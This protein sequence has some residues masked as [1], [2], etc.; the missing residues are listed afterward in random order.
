ML[1]R[2]MGNQSAA[3]LL[4]VGVD[5]RLQME[6][7]RVCCCLSLPLA[8]RCQDGG[9]LFR[10]YRWRSRRAGQ[11]QGNGLATQTVHCRHRGG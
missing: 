2:D 8:D 3:Y 11:G 5:C 4:P 1:L 6:F 7:A 10:G 9:M